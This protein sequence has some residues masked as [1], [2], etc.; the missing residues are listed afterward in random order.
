MWYEK[1]SWYTSLVCKQV[2]DQNSI[3]TSYRME[4]WSSKVFI[5]RINSKAFA[6]PI[7]TAAYLIN[8]CK[9]EYR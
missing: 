6:I 9:P 1:F 4:K 2:G 5:H 8:H 7:L 3:E